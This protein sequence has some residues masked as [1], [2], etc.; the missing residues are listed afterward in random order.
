M[1]GGVDVNIHI[2]TFRFRPAST[3]FSGDPILVFDIHQANEAI[4]GTHTGAVRANQRDLPQPCPRML[5]P[6]R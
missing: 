6:A 2:H 1:L 5:L 4:L 3:T